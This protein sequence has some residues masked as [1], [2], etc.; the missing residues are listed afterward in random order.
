MAFIVIS[1]IVIYTYWGFMGRDFEIIF[2]YGIFGW[3]LAYIFLFSA[4]LGFFER[5]K[6]RIRPN[7]R[8]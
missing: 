8:Q 5:G 4:Y 1:N 6:K 3:F 7:E 2:I